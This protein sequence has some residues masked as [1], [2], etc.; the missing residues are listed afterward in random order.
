MLIFNVVNHPNNKNITW[1]DVN[2]NMTLD[3]FL[4]CAEHL[5]ILNLVEE[6]QHQEAE[7]SG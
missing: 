1:T 2:D 3:E 5:E 7:N 6:K 4:L